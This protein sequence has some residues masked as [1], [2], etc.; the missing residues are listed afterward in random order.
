MRL[1]IQARRLLSFVNLVEVALPNQSNNQ[2]RPETHG[3]AP[4]DVDVGA[5]SHG[6]DRKLGK[7]GK[8]AQKSLGER[9]FRRH[10]RNGHQQVPRIRF[11][12]NV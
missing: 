8:V 6:R 11:R 12:A 3:N 1:A 5:L 9:K 10:L 7:E 2:P 4:E